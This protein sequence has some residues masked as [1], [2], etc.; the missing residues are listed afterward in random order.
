MMA[1]RNRA[2]DPIAPNLLGWRVLTDI[3]FREW[4]ATY[5]AHQVTKS[6]AVHEQI[7]QRVAEGEDRITRVGSFATS[8]REKMQARLME[9]FG[10]HVHTGMREGLEKKIRDDCEAKITAERIC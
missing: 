7:L 2:G 4:V 3:D 5:L 1:V 10:E 8:Q 6:E 9:Q